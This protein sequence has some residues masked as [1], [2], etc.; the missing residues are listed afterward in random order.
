M[1]IFGL[2]GAFHYV[3]LA[4]SLDALTRHRWPRGV[5]LV[6][7]LYAAGAAHI[8]E[9]LIYAGGYA[10]GRALQFGG[11]QNEAEMSFTELFYFSLVNFTSLGLANVYPTEHLRFMAGVEALN[12]F[13]L[14]SASASFIF[15]L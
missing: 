1:I 8:A 5:K 4:F 13:L 2:C 3:A 12:G 10:L 9:T 15:L 14:I 6:A 7:G 11:F